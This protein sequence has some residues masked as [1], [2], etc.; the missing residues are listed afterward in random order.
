[1][2][3]FVE[4]DYATMFLDGATILLLIII[5]V[6]SSEDR[7]RGREDDKRFF[8]LLIVNCIMAVGDTIAYIFEYKPLALSTVYS[9]IGMT[10]FYFSFVLVVM[11]WADYC[12][13][14]FKE[15]GVSS[16]NIFRPEYIP[17][18]IM[19]ALVLI[20]VF[21]GWIFSYDRVTGDYYRGFLFIVVYIVFALYATMGF[22]HVGRYRSRNSSTR[23]IPMS[24]YI[25]PIIFGFIFTFAVKGSASFAS[26]GLGM[27]FTFTYIG[28]INESLNISYKKSVK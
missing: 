9:T 2:S 12:R 20:N 25:L 19:L 23:L 17:G 7:K 14:R 26:I 16:G 24:V 22:I 6:M 21:T 27:A 5:M 8:L 15:R 18:L 10:I 3:F 28:T 11:I 4:R 13:I 1:M